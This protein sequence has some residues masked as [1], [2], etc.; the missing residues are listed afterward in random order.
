MQEK[1]ESQYDFSV[2]Y[3]KEILSSKSLVMP[4]EPGT[5]T[6]NVEG[7]KYQLEF[8]TFV[9]GNRVEKGE[10]GRIVFTDDQKDNFRYDC[11][12]L[13]DSNIYVKHNALTTVTLASSLLQEIELLELHYKKN[14]VVYRCQVVSKPIDKPN[15]INPENPDPWYIE[16]WKFL[17]K[18]GEVVLRFFG[19]TAPEIVCGGLGAFLC[20]V[21]IL[22]SP[23]LIAFSIWL[24]I[25]LIKLPFKI[26]K[27]I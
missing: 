8:E 21:G 16:L 7:N 17:V 2:K 1:W 11:S 15:P 5:K 25:S 9:L 23:G 12:I 27:K 18:F 19:Q 20:V 4:Y 10:F 24:I 26:V 22:C 13:L 14:N 6:F 3:T